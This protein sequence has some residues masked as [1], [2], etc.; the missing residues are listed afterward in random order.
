[1]PDAATNETTDDQPDQPDQFRVLVT[2]VHAELS[3]D[4]RNLVLA[5]LLDHVAARVRDDVTCGTLRDANGNVVGDFGI[6]TNRTA[7]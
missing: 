3:G 5:D 7:P 2:F 4:L 6:R 1:M